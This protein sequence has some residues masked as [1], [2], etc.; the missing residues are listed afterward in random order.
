M[1][2]NVFTNLLFL[3]DQAPVQIK[4]AGLSVPVKQALLLALLAY[5]KISMNVLKTMFCVLSDVTILQVTY[6]MYQR[7]IL[8]DKTAT[9][10]ELHYLYF[11]IS[12]SYRC[13]CP[14]GYAVAPDRMHCED[15]DEC[16][17]EAN[18]C[19]YDCKNLIGSFM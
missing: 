8:N 13:V 4:K 17:T 2:G 15:I 7:N 11:L 19:R 18:D 10:T 16:S 6:V 1:F 12:G 5:A 9:I 14:Y 3:F